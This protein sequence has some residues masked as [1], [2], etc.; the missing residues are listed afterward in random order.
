[1]GVLDIRRRQERL[2]N[3]GAVQ[4]VNT[5]NGAVEAAR[6]Q[7]AAARQLGNDIKGFGRDLGVAAGYLGTIAARKSE[8][9]I[10]E[11]VVQYQRGMN[12]YN[13][14]R[15]A[16]GEDVGA[17]FEKVYA[18]AMQTSP[19]LGEKGALSLVIDDEAKWLDNNV[20]FRDAFAAQLKEDM[21]LSDAQYDTF[22]RRVTGFD[23][24][25]QSNWVRCADKA[26]T[27]REVGDA[28]ARF[29][30]ATSAVIA[31]DANAASWVEW[32]DALDSSLVAGERAAGR[33]FT[34][35]EKAVARRAAALTVC[36]TGVTQ[37]LSDVTEA[38]TQAGAR[39]DEVFDKAIDAL[40]AQGGEDEGGA[41]LPP[42]S[43]IEDEKTGKQV[44]LLSDALGDADMGAFRKAA[45]EDLEAAKVKWE[46]AMT[47]NTKDAFESG[48]N[49]ILAIPAPEESDLLGQKEYQREVAAGYA[50][51]IAKNPNVLSGEGDEWIRDDMKKFAPGK[52]A[53]ALR[54]IKGAEGK[55]DAARV[56]AN[57]QIFLRSFVVGVPDASVAGGRRLLT[58]REKNDLAEFLY[59]NEEISHADYARAKKQVASETTPLAERFLAIVAKDV[60]SSFPSVC[61]WQEDLMGYGFANTDKARKLASQKTG[62]ESTYY[63]E[64]G[65]DMTERLLFNE[66]ADCASLVMQRIV[67]TGVKPGESEADLLLRAK[68]EFDKL[69]QG[70]TDGIYRLSIKRRQDAYRRNTQDLTNANRARLN[71]A[72][73]LP[74][75]MELSKRTLTKK[76]VE[77]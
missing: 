19:G 71:V 39:G 66:Y 46:R 24:S 33:A 38:A 23:L 41:F 62:V 20:R 51:L 10:D 52:V 1:M 58:T 14:G 34:D 28:K 15:R 4:R 27:A 64:S 47:A 65:D 42:S 77:R 35:T 7:G 60:N 11:A 45:V 30:M 5:D 59:V 3:L 56:K 12:A 13:N 9:E 48:Q 18:T 75:G 40:K 8:R 76:E 67:A 61:K 26:A 63:T 57:G 17:S 36:K 32:R 16:D 53:V 54:A 69:T 72:E 25:T 74:R 44:S 21:G 68:A 31:P 55:A 43:F 6:I 29:E 22:R 70:T 49:D 2:G 73:G 37:F 50:R